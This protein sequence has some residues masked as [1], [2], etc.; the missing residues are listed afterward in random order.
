M[1]S[2]PMHPSATPV[3][4]DPFAA[5]PLARV[6]PSTEAQ[7]EIWLAC[8]L[9]TEASLA[10]NESVRVDLRGPLDWPGLRAAL[11]ALTG[12]HD[13]LRATFS[14]DG[15][16]MLI[17]ETV[18]IDLP[19]HDLSEL[20]N[21]EKDESLQAHIHADVDSPFDLEHGPL[22]RAQLVQLA[23]EHAVLV[24]TAHHIVCDGWS[25]GVLLEEL[26]VL[27]AQANSDGSPRILPPAE[28]YATY[29]VEKTREDQNRHLEAD[30][31]YWIAELTP[32]P[33]SL[34]LPTDAARPQQRSFASRREDFRI[35]EHE[36]IAL[37]QLAASQGLS[38]FA[39][40]FG[41]YGA[42][43]A[44]LSGQSDVVVGVSSADQAATGLRNLVGH[45]VNLLPLRLHVDVE[46]SFAGYAQQ[47]RGKVLDAQE[48][49]SAGFG[50]LLQHLHV[51][52][53][54]SRLP[55]VSV[56][57]NLDTRIDPSG[58]APTG[59]RSQI[60]SNPRSAE[61]F[62]LYLNVTQEKDHLL[63]ECQYKTALF[64]QATIA[65]WLQLYHSALQ[66]A[67]ARPGSSL[68]E[69]LGPPD[70]ELRLLA[71]WNATRRAYPQHLRLSDVLV[72]GMRQN[73]QATALVFEGQAL[74]HGQLLARASFLARK[75]R[76]HGA[77]PGVLVGVCAPRGIELTV[78]LL[79]VCLSGAAY[80]PLEP[81]L[82]TSRLA[83]MVADAKLGLLLAHTPD[84]DRHAAAFGP[85]LPTIS[86]DVALPGLDVGSEE[87]DLLGVPDDPA[88]V[89]FTSGST[90]RPKGAIN[91][92]RGIVNRLLWM[93][94]AY[95]LEPGER[96]LQKT[97]FSFDVSVW[98]FFWPLMV[99][100]TLVVAKPD[101]HRDSA[102][103]VELVQR[104]R[105]DVLHFVP[106]MLHFFLD[107]PAATQCTSVRRVV[108]SGEALPRELVERFF[109]VL[110]QARLANLYGPTEAAVDVS[111]WECRPDASAQRVPIGAPIA[112]TQLHVLDAGLRPLPIGVAGEMY[113]G[114]VQ[115]GLGYVSQADLTT[116]RFLPDP[117]NPG[118]RLYKTGDMA[119]W[120]SD[121]ALDYLGRI[122]DQIKLRGYRIE[123]GEIEIR[124]LA[125]P[126]VSQAVA[127]AREDQPGDMR[128][129]AYVTGASSLEGNALRQAL[130]AQLPD[131]M[132]PACVLPL[133]AIPL[134]SNGKVNRRALPA[135]SR[136]VGQSDQRVDARNPIEKATIAAMENVLKL[137]G[138]SV[139]DDFF[140]LGGHSL[141][142]ARLIAQIN[143]E[144]DLNLPL[145][146]VFQAPTAEQLAAVVEHER[147][148]GASR[149]RTIAHDP[150]RI[151]AP[152]S[153]QQE[154]IAFMEE[155]Q[156]GRVTY[157]APSAH[158]LRGSL[159]VA[160][161]EAALRAMVQ[162][163]PVLR[164]VIRRSSEGHEQVVLPVV[165]LTL[166][167]IDL[168]G[169]PDTQ[170][171]SELM[172]RMQ[173]IVDQPIDIHEAPLF[174][175]ALFK[176]AAEEHAFLFMPHHIIWDGW[177][178]DLLYV[179]MATLYPACSAGRPEASLLPPLAVTYAD[180]AAWQRQ[181]MQADDFGSLMQT[182]KTRIAGAPV[183][184]APNTD[185][186]RSARMSGEG[187]TEWVRIDREMT[188]RVRSIARENDVTLNM[189]ML[190]LYAA[191]MA[192][193]AESPSV[194][195]GV[196]TRARSIAE[197]E[198]VMGFFN[199]LLPLQLQPDPNQ[200]FPGFM[201]A[202]KR[203]LLDLSTFQDVPFECLM[204]EPE[205]KARSQQSGLYQA[206][207]SF[208][209]ARDRNRSWGGIKQSSI[210]IFQ[211]G[212]TEDLGLWLME[213][214]H[215]L[216]GG[217]TYNADIYTAQTASA[218]RER[219]LEL[220]VRLADRPQA[221]LAELLDPQA[222][223]VHAVL[224]RLAHVVQPSAPAVA[225]AVAQTCSTLEESRFPLGS[226]EQIIRDVWASVLGLPLDQ[227]VTQDNF[228]DL[229][230]D[231]LS[232]MRAVQHMFER[233]GK[234]ANARILIF[235]NLEQIARHYD[236][237]AL[238]ASTKPSLLRR[239]FGSGRD[240][241]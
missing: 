114:G 11:Q 119:R 101:G 162:R 32:T 64:E 240:A 157:N 118:G 204:A 193:I 133:P 144:F 57:F 139:H 73:P 163:Q 222:S 19:A 200:T 168:S 165:D 86:L 120:R 30:V 108:C 71:A 21:A 100:A 17:A 111:S 197:V 219:Y 174:R 161:F 186:P 45:C 2:Q 126:S 232:A 216:E 4:Y 185:K 110:P 31:Q 42:M 10:Y 241:G 211:K 209:D 5:T 92:H 171:E 47:V 112:N 76:T 147:A 152:L 233:T 54:P 183:P 68:A 177:S 135:P 195:I 175:V 1:S 189:A 60:A 29:A 107:E 187:A 140:A 128:I 132:V 158:R 28:S 225:L 228:F 131:Y 173:A 94:E 48:H 53:D 239:L 142:A 16:E 138:M 153:A 77:G 164:T 70:D 148:Q 23:D 81:S 237:M 176:L 182:W 6:V 72:Q 59:L 15:Q 98:E 18:Q 202:V 102:Y 218:M 8:Q 39:L 105:I 203:E 141:L 151:T 13:A 156:P 155:L 220:V 214:P 89:L 3:D 41:M 231:S 124:L 196:P 180:Y 123:L 116:E 215:G 14:A 212:A 170:R 58:F 125:L 43:V 69:L 40:L 22:L 236:G 55:L 227:V 80:V 49:Q 79:G 44:R 84:R 191:M 117:F 150:A 7:R 87:I 217:I 213:V 33:P 172:R 224:R 12:R 90:G 154:R 91:S 85:D 75:L 82:P 127:V 24:L 50:R 238:D 106:S 26:P 134:L 136:A 192:Q 210:L 56:L 226:T 52:R 199:N 88:Y 146:A 190:G 179:E 129:V 194:V 122:D 113:I 46:H 34:E 208:Q 206:L 96:V 223:R 143:R 36:T 235:Q 9:G 159:D 37:R 103:L 149:R 63:L 137:P 62:E 229:G 95:A 20:S 74:T 221:A 167:L 65:R 99:G 230:G 115:V 188:E 83:D 130:R 93:Q 201:R 78:A 104:Q 207:F 61:N 178:F 234:R 35:D 166:P 38:L 205:V 109:A 169:V 145:R 198:P 160:A 97:P 184:H 51:P 25:F 181:W 27:L 67:V 66:G 121:G